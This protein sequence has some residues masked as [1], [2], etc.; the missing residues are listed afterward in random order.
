MPGVYFYHG[1]Q[2]V[3]S[4]FM[5]KTCNVQSKWDMYITKERTST[6]MSIGCIDASSYYLYR[7]I[8]IDL[9]NIS[10]GKDNVSTGCYVPK[11]Q[12]LRSSGLKLS[13]TYL[14]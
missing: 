12:A 14:P 5:L 4:T 8:I 6:V 1:S 3:I 7:S 11:R 13:S 2:V 9:V 10:L